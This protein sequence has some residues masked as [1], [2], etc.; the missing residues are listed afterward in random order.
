L[1]NPKKIMHP[2]QR[3]RKLDEE[4]RKNKNKNMTSW[5]LE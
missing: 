3:R 4:I 2:F 1:E 5:A